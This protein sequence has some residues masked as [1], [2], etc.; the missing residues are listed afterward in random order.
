MV[1]VLKKLTGD[2]LAGR[3][4]A[5][6]DGRAYSPGEAPPDG[7]KAE[8]PKSKRPIKT[9]A[10]SA[11]AP[12]K[13]AAASVSGPASRIAALETLWGAGRFSPASTDLYSRITSILPDLENPSSEVF[14]LLN[15]DPAWLGQLLG[16]LG[17]I[18]VIAEWRSPCIDRF[19]KEYPDFDAFTGD[20][21]RP[22]FDPGSLRVAFSQDAFAFADHKAGLASRMTRSLAPG[23]QWLV[24]DTVRG[25]P[26][27]SLAP[28]FA[29]AWAEP[30]LPTEEEI[31][32]VCETAG[33]ELVRD[34]DD[35]TGDLTQACRKSLDLFNES[36]E[37]RLSSAL[38]H[39]NKAVF[40]QELGWEAETWKW[41]ER[42]YAA[43][44][45]HLKLWKF[46]KPED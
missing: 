42:A 43:E 39:V 28:A 41:R 19:R 10:K 13:A 16:S 34:G 22:S 15:S 25:K 3:L 27:K 20:L 33:L 37:D 29:S 26:A 35:L 40:M 1:A 18:P 38:D 8:K 17:A 31:I 14:G 45:M 6:W 7:E 36:L 32:E 12:V 9:E 30:Q 11:P 46:K 4:G 23:G 44:F 5:W 21:D 24:L 2:D